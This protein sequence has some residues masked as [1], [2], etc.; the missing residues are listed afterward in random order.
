MSAG[1]RV[2]THQLQYMGSVVSWHMESC[3][4]RNGN[5]VPYIG[6]QILNHWTTR[7]VLHG[8]ILIHKLVSPV[9]SK[10]ITLIFGIAKMATHSSTLAWKSHRQRSLVGYSPC[11]CKESDTTERLHFL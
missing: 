1:S 8:T 6:R 11:G 3:W 10:S 4:V 7:E 2:Q 9:L 5:C